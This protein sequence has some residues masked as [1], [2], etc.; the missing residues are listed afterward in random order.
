MLLG[1][2]EPGYWAYVRHQPEFL[3]DEPD[4]VDR[5]SRRIVDQLARDTGCTAF[6]P[7]GGP[8]YYPFIEWALRSGRCWQSPVLFLVHDVAGLMVSFRAALCHPDRLELPPLTRS[9][10]CDTCDGQPCISACPVDAVSSDAFEA[11]RCGDYMKSRSGQDCLN[12]GCNVR[13]SCPLS[14][15]Y[16]RSE[17]QSRLHQKAFLKGLSP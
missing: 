2:H 8:P 4:P 1:P 15:S 9:S 6:Y 14:I 12:R 13:R 7:F 3:D 17:E 16:G 5:W 11:M 10:P